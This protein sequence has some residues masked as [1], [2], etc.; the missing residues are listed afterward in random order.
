MTEEWTNTENGLTCSQ[1]ALP[2]AGAYR[3]T[4][5]DS[6]WRALQNFQIAPCAR[7]II[8]ASTTAQRLTLVSVLGI[9]RQ[10]HGVGTGELRFATFHR[11]R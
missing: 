8:P 3:I 11:P 1:A 6:F 5:V 10:V 9:F 4:F 7:F 2:G